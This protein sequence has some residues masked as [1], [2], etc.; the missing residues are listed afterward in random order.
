MGNNSIEYR[1][2]LAS[3][4]S[5]TDFSARHVA[6]AL[7]RITGWLL[8]GW[9]VVHLGLPAVTTGPSVWNPL[10][11]LPG[12]LSRVVVVG[13]LSVLVFHIFNGIRLLAAELFGVGIKTTRRVFLWTLATSVLLV[14]G[15][16][17]ML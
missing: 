7:H 3:V 13:L 10:R 6:F 9:V 16:G 14:I 4:K 5:W 17:V 15:L 1:R 2:K 8:L 12:P 11:D